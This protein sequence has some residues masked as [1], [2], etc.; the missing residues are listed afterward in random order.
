[1]SYETIIYEKREKVGYITLNRP[2]EGNAIN[3]QLNRELIDVC[4][5][6]TEDKDVLVVVLT[7]AGEGF[8]IGSDPHQDRETMGAA[9]AI[10]SIDHPVI[11]AINGDALGKGLEL[12]LS[13]DVRLAS[14]NATFG[15]PES[16]LGLIPMDGGTQRLPRI[17]GRGKAMEMIL[18]AEPID[19]Q[20]A[21][22]IGLVN[23]VVPREKLLHEAEEMANRMASRG[24]IALRYAKEAVL[25]G[26]DLTLEQGLR[27]EGDL[28]FLLQTTED[29][30]EGIRSF[31][32]RR[33]PQFK[34]K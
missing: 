6:V 2:H 31:L 11:A 12:A 32:E 16:S 22:R 15:F 14:E 23:R 27:L 29:I 21:Y 19:A 5:Q 33:T 10:A 24:P 7:G 20:E 28:Y 18:I 25:K 3:A 4:R 30:A 1:M 34:G 17:V 9:Q 8:S 13:S 26:L